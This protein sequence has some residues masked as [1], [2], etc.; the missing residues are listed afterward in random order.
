MSHV[1]ATASIPKAVSGAYRI[2]EAVHR[3]ARF[4]GFLLSARRGPAG[5][6]AQT[7]RQRLPRLSRVRDRAQRDEPDGGIPTTTT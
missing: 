3:V 1:K 4:M 2:R 7:R 6:T 5:T